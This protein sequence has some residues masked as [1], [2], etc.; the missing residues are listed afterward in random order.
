MVE[1]VEQGLRRMLVLAVA[2]VHDGGLDVL[3]QQVGEPAWRVANH[4][5]V[6]AH[7]IE[8]GRGVDEGSRLWSSTTPTP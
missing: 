2:G 7:G 1:A 6:R 3:G 4:H 8:I 5:D